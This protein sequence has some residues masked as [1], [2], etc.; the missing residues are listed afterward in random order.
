MIKQ[1]NET[2]IKIGHQAFANKYD[3]NHLKVLFALCYHFC[4]W[5]ENRINKFSISELAAMCHKSER[6]VYTSLDYLRN[7]KLI[8]K[9]DKY[10]YINPM[11][12]CRCSAKERED[13]FYFLVDRKGFVFPELEKPTPK[14]L[15][16]DFS[17]V[18]P[19]KTED[20]FVQHDILVKFEANAE[21][22]SRKSKARTWMQPGDAWEMPEDDELE[23]YM[24]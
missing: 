19:A 20:G 22:N 15:I 18:E 23:L 13:L 4:Y 9:E 6:R 24:T 10:E 14:K 16:Y 17:K 7:K 1:Q 11:I 21:N 5:K 12:C 2:F 8:I 3:G